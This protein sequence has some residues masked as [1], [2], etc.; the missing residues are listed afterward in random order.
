MTSDALRAIVISAATD[1]EA[2]DLLVS[3]LVESVEAKRMLRAA[4]YGCVG[5][6]LLDT[7]REVIA[8]AACMHAS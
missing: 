4:G 5:L 3:M 7:T 1:S 2:A 8:A 6:G